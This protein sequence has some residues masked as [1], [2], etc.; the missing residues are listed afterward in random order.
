MVREE[1]PVVSVLQHTV[2]RPSQLQPAKRSCSIEWWLING[3]QQVWLP[4]CWQRDTSACGLVCCHWRRKNM[5]V[6]PSDRCHT[7]TCFVSGCQILYVV[8]G[9]WRHSLWD[10]EPQCDWLNNHMFP[11]QW[12]LLPIVCAFVSPWNV[13]TKPCLFSPTEQHSHNTRQ[14]IDE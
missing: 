14:Y 5:Q 10:K 9:K 11:R 8:A 4:L 2:Y 3:G 12:I 1:V 6:K 13:E 7:E